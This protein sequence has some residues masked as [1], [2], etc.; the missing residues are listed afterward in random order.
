VLPVMLSVV[1][2]VPVTAAVDELG[3]SVVDDIAVSVAVRTFAH[4]L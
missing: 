3:C 4:E 2:D 1:A